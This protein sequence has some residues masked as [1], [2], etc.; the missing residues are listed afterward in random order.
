[1]PRHVHLHCGNIFRIITMIK[2][3]KV[4]MQRNAYKNV[5]YLF[6][7]FKN[8]KFTFRQHPR[9]KTPYLGSFF[10]VKSSAS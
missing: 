4:K 3:C 10:G 5:P 9:E 2:C 1:M 6:L 7:N 8:M